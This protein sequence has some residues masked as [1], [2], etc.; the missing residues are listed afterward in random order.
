MRAC[1]TC[2]GQWGATGLVAGGYKGDRL[3]APREGL[4]RVGSGHPLEDTPYE[5]GLGFDVK[6][7]KGDFVGRAAPRRRSEAGAAPAL[8]TLAD[9]R[10]VALGS[11]PV[12][13][14]DELVGRVTSGGYG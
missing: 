6:V 11:G 1:G 14:G 4:P 8:L 12:R 7:D 13:V 2:S 10:A 3:A 5:A 9:A